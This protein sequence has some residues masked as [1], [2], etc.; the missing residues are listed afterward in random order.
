MEK[1]YF[2][3]LSKK[4][5]APTKCEYLGQTAGFD[6]KSSQ[7]TV[8]PARGSALISTDIKVR[9]P[10]GTYG[11]LAPR[12]GLAWKNKIDVGAGVIDENYTGPLFVLLFN[13]SD[14]DFHVIEG[15]RI[16]QLICTRISYPILEEVQ[17]LPVFKNSDD[18]NVREDKGFGSSGN[19]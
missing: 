16:A 13:H 8:V 19:F 18:T 11:R 2:V 17:T 14:I 12:S 3:K 6:L 15:E 4:A 5:Q 7:N 10:P 1:L 9:L